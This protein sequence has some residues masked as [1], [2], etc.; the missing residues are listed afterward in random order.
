MKNLLTSLVKLEDVNG[1]LVSREGKPLFA[2]LP[3]VFAP[4]LQEVLYH[5]FEELCTTFNQSH[6][7][8][9]EELVVLFERGSVVVKELKGFQ[10]LLILKTPTPS[11]LVSVALNALTLKL[12]KIAQKERPLHEE[13]QELVPLVLF[14]EL[15]KLL[16]THYGPAAKLIAKKAL[17]QAEAKEKG[18]P[19]AN[20][21][22]FLK[23]LR[24]EID[25]PRLAQI[26]LNKAK[27][28]LR[29]GRTK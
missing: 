10:V 3:E 12:E 14:N 2:H 19:L 21:S 24:A 5:S 9:A 15:V 11:P 28:I 6:Q 17:K 22:L 29:S 13:D 27:E 16:V 26:A 18:L 7:D 4:E 8:E 20:A 23:A 25:D 1:L